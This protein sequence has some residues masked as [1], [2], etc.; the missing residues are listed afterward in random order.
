M[1]D[2]QNPT[3]P[4]FGCGQALSPALEELDHNQP[5]G[6]TIFRAHGQ[7]GSTVFDP[8]NWGS[9]VEKFLEIN[10]CDTCLVIGANKVLYTEQAM[11][12]PQ[13]LKRAT[14]VPPKEES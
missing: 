4:C 6:A 12:K 9:G 7:Y 10:I 3:L 11:L 1:T 13:T 14:W 5:Y 2:K 8:M